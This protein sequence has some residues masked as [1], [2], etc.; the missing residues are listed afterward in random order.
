MINSTNIVDQRLIDTFKISLVARRGE[1]AVRLGDYEDF[2]RK[3]TNLEKHRRRNL[4]RHLTITKN[5]R[6]NSMNFDEESEFG[7][8]KLP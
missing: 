3:E 4:K 2:D 1:R 5:F 6:I 8:F 7:S